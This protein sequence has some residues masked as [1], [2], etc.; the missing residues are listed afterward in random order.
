[1]LPAHVFLHGFDTLPVAPEVVARLTPLLGDPAFTADDLERTIAFDP[2]LTANL[3]QAANR[4]LGTGAA[5]V[6]G[7]RQAAERVGL[8]RLLATAVGASLRR[9]LPS[10]IPGYGI[11]SGKFWIHCIAVATISE[12]IARRI[13]LPAAEVAFTAGLLHDVGQLAIGLFFAENSPE[14][15]WWTFGTPAE[16]RSFL[17]CNHCDVGLLVARR[18]SLP[19]PVSDACRWHHEPAEAPASIDTGLNAVVHAADA[20]AYTLG[21]RGVGYPGEVLHPAAPARLGLAE[22]ELLALARGVRRAIGRNAV[23][24]GMGASLDPAQE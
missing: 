3:L 20:L 12:A 13:A 22:A 7:L 1:M 18:W 2:V 8:Q 9:G 15:D 6:T 21:Y 19:G 10:R 23:A 24:S 16:E 5:P 4:A 17:G 14:A 11:A